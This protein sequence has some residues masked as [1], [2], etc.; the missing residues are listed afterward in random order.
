MEMGQKM[1]AATATAIP[2]ATATATATAMPMATATA[3][4]MATATVMPTATATATVPG[5][6]S[7]EAD[8]TE[9]SKNKAVFFIIAY[10]SVA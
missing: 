8:Q 2:M 3:M 4:P 10:I 6:V 1:P 5:R 9:E 7:R